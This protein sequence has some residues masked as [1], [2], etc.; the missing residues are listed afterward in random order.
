MN[1]DM[2]L[3]RTLLTKIGD[4][5]QYNGQYTYHVDA[6]DFDIEGFSYGDID[7]HLGLLIEA[8]LLNGKR[9]ASPGFSIKGLSWEGHE[10]LDDT[11]DPEIWGKTNARAK[12]LGGLGL[13]FL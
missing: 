13:S 12:T 9:M 10:F 2:D 4:D 8:E 11:R 1:R 3:V 7:Y 6:S 5:P